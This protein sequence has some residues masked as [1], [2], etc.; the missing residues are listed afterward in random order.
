MFV[1]DSSGVPYNLFTAPDRQ[2]IIQSDYTIHFIV[3]DFSPADV[4]VP[5]IVYVFVDHFAELR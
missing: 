1:Y 4:L 3:Q 2:V 5:G